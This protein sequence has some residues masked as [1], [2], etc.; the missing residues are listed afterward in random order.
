M[1][2]SLCRKLW[3]SKCWNQLVGDFDVYLHAKKATSSLT[4]FLRYC[5]DI[6]HLL[7][8]ELW[9]CLTIPIKKIIVSIY[10]KLS[11]LYACNKSPSS[12]TFFSIYCKELANLLFWVIWACLAT[13]S[14]NLKKSLMFNSK[15][16]TIF[17]LS[18]SHEIL[19]RYCKFVILNTLRKP[20]YT[21]PKWY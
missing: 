6:A 4:S 3:C 18:I 19:Q 10:R 11:Y 2:V 5:K 8:W 12:F 13:S 7:F 14:I 15:Q 21:P 20:A 1:I 9:E 16:K 17:I